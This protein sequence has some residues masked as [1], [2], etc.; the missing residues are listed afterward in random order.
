VLQVHNNR[1]T[2]VQSAIELNSAFPCKV[3]LLA[4]AGATDKGETSSH[5][6]E[7]AFGPGALCFDDICEP[8]LCFDICEPS[9]ER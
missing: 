1:S 9:A 3:A 6:C 8:A 2:I 5:V 7:A 4:K